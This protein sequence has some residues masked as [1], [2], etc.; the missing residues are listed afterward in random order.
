MQRALLEARKGVGRT[1]PNPPVGAVVVRGALLLG[2]GFHAKAGERHAEVVALDDAKAKGHDVRGATL[3]VTLEPCAHHG[4]TPPCVQRVM[5][6][7]IGRVVIGAVDPNLRVHGKGIDALRAAGIEVAVL[8]ERAVLGEECRALIE[9]FARATVEGRPYVVLKIASSLDGRIATANGASRWITGS[10]ARALVHRLRDAVDAVVVGAGTVLADDPSLT[11]R[12]ARAAS[13]GGTR[14]P[15]RVV[16]DSALRTS[17]TSRVYQARA[18]ERAPVVVHAP[19][20]ERALMDAF[21][22]AG[23]RRLVREA[24]VDVAPSAA[25]GAPAG[26]AHVDLAGALRALVPLGVM[27]VLLEAGPGLATAALAAGIVD[28]LWW[29]QAPLLLGADAQPAVGPLALSAPADG[30]RFTAVH[31]AIIGEDALVILAA[32]RLHGVR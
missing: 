3:H 29:F 32:H 6:E 5:A 8:E 7:G 21:D 1:A 10:A 13:D 2:T 24:D 27:A 11:V 20:A 16:I 26:G 25:R 9:P 28:E 12:D 22:A 31:R 4:R 19:G 15:M 30:P 17:P 18:G 14:D 23:V